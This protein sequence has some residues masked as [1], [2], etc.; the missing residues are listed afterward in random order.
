MAVTLDLALYTFNQKH[1]APIPNLKT[2]QQ[3][4]PFKPMGCLLVQTPLGRIWVITTEKGL[5]ALIL[6]D[7]KGKKPGDFWGW[8]EPG[9]SD[10]G[11]GARVYGDLL[12]YFRG[13]AVD[14]H[15]PL[16]LRGVTDFQQAVWRVVQGVPPGQVRSYKWVA[17]KIGRPSSFRTVGRALAQN[18]LP[19][20]IPCHRIVRAD[21]GLGDFSA[22][23]KWKKGLLELEGVK[24]DLHHL[25][26]SA[27]YLTDH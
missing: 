1:Y 10:Q 22:D 16:D 3:Y 5:R 2:V 25:K 12:R 27:D 24:V 13:E 21:G 18:P 4:F 14:F 6:D 26:V 9:V 7:S 19:I 15:Y 20:I 23:L 8:E 11:L 17:R